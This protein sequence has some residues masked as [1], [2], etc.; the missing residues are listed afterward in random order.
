MVDADNAVRNG[1]PPLTVPHRIIYGTA[2]GRIHWF[3]DGKLT[4]GTFVSPDHLCPDLLRY[5][6][7]GAA[8][9]WR[10]R[11]V[12]AFFWLMRAWRVADARS[13]R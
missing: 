10:G 8:D 4:L 7:I 13:H 5:E 3:G 9:N 11:M 2:D 1:Y 6:Q 12:R